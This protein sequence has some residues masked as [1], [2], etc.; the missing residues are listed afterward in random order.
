MT[1]LHCY[2]DV[3]KGSIFHLPRTLRTLSAALSDS[4]YCLCIFRFFLILAKSLESLEIKVSLFHI[5]VETGKGY[6]ISTIDYCKEN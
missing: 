4:Q 6:V 3:I 5:P 2:N 1:P